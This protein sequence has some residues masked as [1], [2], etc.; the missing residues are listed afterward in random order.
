MKKRMVLALLLVMALMTACSSGSEYHIKVTKDVYFEAGKT[1]TIEIKVTEDRKAVEGLTIKALLSM[2]NMAHGTSEVKFTDK[3]NGIY[4]GEADLSMSGKYEAVFIVEKNGKK[5]E[6]V[7]E[8]EVKKAEG[9]AKINGEWITKEEINFYKLINQLQL[10]MNR[11]TARKNYSGEK[12]KE[13]LAYLDSQ[14]T[15]IEDQNQLLTQIIRLR[16][17]AVLAEEKGHTATNEEVEEAIKKVRGQYSQFE[18]AS[19]MIKEYGE[20]KFWATEREHY[21]MIVLSQKIQKDLIDKIKKE[22]PSYGEQEIYYQAQKQYEEL[23]IS[24]VN[25]LEIEIL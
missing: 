9:V 21:K 18:S 2:K 25:T 8:I 19:N 3:G 17:M 16:S 12:L 7:I 5:T 6:K 10:E 11:E 13:E 4:S 14:K 15:N 23:L 1:S 20:E 22:N 24:Q